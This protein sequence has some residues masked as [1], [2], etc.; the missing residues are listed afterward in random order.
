MRQQVNES[1]RLGVIS[2]G[3]LAK[4]PDFAHT[5]SMSTMAW[6]Q[7]LQCIQALAPFQGQRSIDDG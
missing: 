5:P 7:Q 2:K 1:L 6:F 4:N 3:C